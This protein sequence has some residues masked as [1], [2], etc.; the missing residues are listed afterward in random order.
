MDSP[1][2]A[3]SERLRL[4]LPPRYAHQFQ[5]SLVN[6]TDL[7]PSFYFIYHHQEGRYIFVEE[8]IEQV[9]LCKP[10][11]MR[12]RGEAFFLSRMHPDDVPHYRKAQERWQSFFQRLPENERTYYT[13]S[14]DFRIRKN[15][16]EYIRLLRQVVCL[17]CDEKGA[18][19]Y[20]LEKCT[21]IS[22]WQKGHDITLSIIGPNTKNNLIFRPA[23]PSKTAKKLFFTSS[24]MKVLELLSQGKTSKETAE[25]LNLSFNTVNT[26]RRNMRRKAGVR[27][28]TSLVQVAQQ[29]QLLS[30]VAR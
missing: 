9:L 17:I 18:P 25:I 12:M 8:R 27:S 3:L 13:S 6:R 7:G 10:G 29:H 1:N 26:H 30:E 5:L 16:G 28:T 21:N 24:E 15:D 19:L 2:Q 4:A 22:H 11:N 20:S 14:L 23:I